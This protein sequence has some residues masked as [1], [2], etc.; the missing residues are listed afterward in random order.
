MVSA[1]QPR[2]TWEAKKLVWPSTEIVDRGVSQNPQDKRTFLGDGDDGITVTLNAMEV[3]TY[4][5]TMA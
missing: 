4:L 5:V 2:A 3:K 1:N